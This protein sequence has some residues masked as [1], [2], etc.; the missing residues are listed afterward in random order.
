MKRSGKIE[1]ALVAGLAMSGCGRKAYDPCAPQNFN[2]AACQDAVNHNGYYYGGRWYSHSYPGGYSWY[3]NGYNSYVRRGGS[4][5]TVPSSEWTGPGTS[6]P[7][8]ARSTGSGV[9]RGIFGS[10]AHG[11]G[12]GE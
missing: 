5:T 1:I 8:G 12:G 3:Y 11:G 7:S 6:D 2:E 9:S 10:S 4:V